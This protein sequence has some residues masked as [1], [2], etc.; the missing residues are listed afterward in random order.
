[1]DVLKKIIKIVF[2]V[3]SNIEFKFSCAAF[4]TGIIFFLFACISQENTFA[5]KMFTYLSAINFSLWLI[6]T[7]GADSTTLF[8]YELVRLIIFFTIFLLSLYVCLS[9]LSNQQTNCFS[10]LTIILSSIGL[11]G[12]SFYF[13]SHFINTFNFI[14]KIFQ[15]VKTTL[16]NTE[17]NVTNKIKALIENITAFLVTIG[18]L[19]VAIKVI[20]ESVFQVLNYL[21]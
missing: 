3:E 13:V 11:L 4:I 21:K 1:M 18:G 10:V 20:A 12:C 9:F 6:I 14:K 2:G 17:N 8:L 19:T 16:F 5:M 7:K 15:Q